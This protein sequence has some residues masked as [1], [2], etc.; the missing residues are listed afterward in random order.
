MT[1]AI[2]AQ[3]LPGGKGNSAKAL[4]NWGALMIETAGRAA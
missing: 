2:F 1:Q 4:F 3:L